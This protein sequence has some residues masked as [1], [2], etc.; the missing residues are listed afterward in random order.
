ME[1]G[2]RMEK[3]KLKTGSLKK[4]ISALYCSRKKRSYKLPVSGIKMRTDSKNIK[5]G[6][7]MNNFILINSAT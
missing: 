3:N 7:H 5:R 4:S 2:Q 6:I 1:N